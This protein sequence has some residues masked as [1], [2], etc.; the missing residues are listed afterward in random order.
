MEQFLQIWCSILDTLDQFDKSILLGINGAHSGFFDAFMFWIS[1][2]WIWVP[3]YV[4]LLYIIAKNKRTETLFIILGIVLTV[5]FCD[6]FSSS[7]CKPLFHRF[8]PAQ[9]PQIGALVHT[10]CG[11]KCD[12]YGFIS[13]HAANTVGVAVFLT[14]LFR[15]K[16]FGFTIFSWALLNCYSRIY[17]G[18][19][20]MGDILCGA[21]V[22]ALFGW[23]CFWLHSL[24]LS[25]MP[26]FRYMQH[27][28]NSRSNVDF[29]NETMIPFYWTYAV[30]L[31]I[32]AVFAGQNI[33]FC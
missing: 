16:V 32:I 30:T 10:V 28:T 12:L 27:R 7:L 29:P 31:F 17:L 2:K 1:D 21:I 15:N 33:F 8:R 19:H 6:Q 11:F 4:S 3:L 9:D 24:M 13:S 26:Q 5:L 23:L 25:W 22:G 20:Y 14:L 18:V